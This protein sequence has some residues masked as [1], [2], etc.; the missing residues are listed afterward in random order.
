MVC[1][2]SLP[3]GAFCGGRRVSHSSRVHLPFFH[4]P[5][6][7]FASACRVSNFQL[8]RLVGVDFVALFGL[9][10]VVVDTIITAVAYFVHF[11]ALCCTPVLIATASNALTIRLGAFSEQVRIFGLKGWATEGQNSSFARELETQC[12]NKAE[13]LMNEYVLALVVWQL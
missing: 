9:P 3:P 5:A 11:L 13:R 10:S 4:R 8:A 6:E 1:F 2:S 7:L 12:V